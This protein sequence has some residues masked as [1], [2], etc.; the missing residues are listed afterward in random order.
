[1]TAAPRLSQTEFIAM[2]AMLFATIAFSIDAMLPAL[3]RI[4]ADLT[5]DTPNAAQLIIT[6]FVFGMGIG[7]LF[8]G[9]LSDSFGRKPVIIGGAALYCVGA[10]LCWVAPSIETMLAAR[11][12]QGLGAAGPR[13]VAIAMVRDLYNGRAMARVVSFVMM[14]FML[15]PAIAP[16][17]GSF[18]IGWAGWR[19][20]FLAFVVFATVATLWL[21][22]R[23]PETLLPRARRPFRLTPLIAALRE[24]IAN[25]TIVISIIVQTLTY[26]CL[27]ATL[28]STQQIFGDTFGRAE[29]F[30]F[31]FALI[32]VM[33]GCG[34][35]LN[36]TL[37]MRMGMH[38][39]VS[40]T[41]AGQVVLSGAMLGLLIGIDLPDAMAFAA[42][43]V[44]TIGVF[45]TVS[46]TIG[47]MNAIALEPVG[48]I[49]GM[50]SSVIGA[51]ST[52]ASLVLA[53][54]V[55]LLFDGTPLPLVTSVAV[56]AF[57]ALLLMRSLIVAS[58]I[59]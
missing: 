58:S 34:S 51:F 10:V 45:V 26:A 30:P 27:F 4:A 50:A 41:L 40:T 46:L 47:N 18:I 14:V 37:V 56:M 44:W 48:H 7:T 33:A 52:V 3:P 55:G 13:V 39:M 42:Y 31:W 23:Q 38:R 59:K 53:V 57:A 29:S 32:S 11:L 21:A 54:P 35:L 12:F 49:A 8:A 36:A 5:P 17:L 6:S 28:S 1:M 43:L 24:V 22:L 2:A 19:A 20:L 25:R 16:L 15:V 9:P